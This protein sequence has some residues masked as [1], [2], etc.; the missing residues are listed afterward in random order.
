MRI[1][2][3]DLPKEMQDQVK[4]KKPK[5]KAEP[6]SLPMFVSMCEPLGLPTPVA[7][8]QFEPTRKWRFDFAFIGNRVAVEVEG[9]AWS[10]GRHTRGGGF[11]GDM[12][13]Y[14]RAAALGWRIIRCTPE[15][16]ASGV[17]LH[18]LAEAMTRMVV[19]G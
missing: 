16:M 10:R 19:D 14:N 2:I 15:Q 3:K 1:N 8:H 13:K 6:T 7:E 17:I 9:G 4:A 5:K 12:D 18:D 11:I